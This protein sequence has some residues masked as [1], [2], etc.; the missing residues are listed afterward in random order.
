MK[1][2]APRIIQA[3]GVYVGHAGRVNH[4]NHVN[5]V[6]ARQLRGNSKVAPRHLRQIRQIWQHCN[7][8]GNAQSGVAGVR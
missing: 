3:V 7:M 5:R 4:V 2:Q 1:E 6:A 8:L